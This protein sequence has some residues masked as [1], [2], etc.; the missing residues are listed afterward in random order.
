M[1]VVS[2]MAHNPWARWFS[3]VEANLLARAGSPDRKYISIN[4]NRGL[5]NCKYCVSYIPSIIIV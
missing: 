2:C 1:K 3:W 5:Y 4:Y